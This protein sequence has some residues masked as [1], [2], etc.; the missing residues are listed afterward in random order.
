M[1]MEWKLYEIGQA[2]REALESIQVDPETG[3]VL[4][5]G[6]I[7]SLAGAFDEKADAVACYIKELAA[8]EE[9]IKKEKQALDARQ[10]AVTKTRERLR[11][12]LSTWM[13][14]VGRDK[15][16]TPR[17]AISW[18]KTASCVVDDEN[19]L[20]EEF[21]KVKIE[22]AKAAITKAIREGIQVPGAHLEE[23]RT[24]QIK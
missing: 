5:M 4:D 17:C 7:T 18:R 21:R 6:S 8:M 24:L 13:E 10:K 15:I 22:P 19:I 12:Y 20:P 11:A 9:G 14:E 3:E 2:Y 16:K 1:K 23:G